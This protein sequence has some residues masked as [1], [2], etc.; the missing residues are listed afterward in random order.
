MARFCS[1]CGKEIEEWAAMCPHCGAQTTD[2]KIPQVPAED[3]TVNPLYII[4][5]I[6]LPIVGII[7]W[8]VQKDKT[9]HAAKTY[10]ITG[11]VVWGLGILLI[12]CA[13]I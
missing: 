8:A 1:K 12:A 5:S 11:L 2:K 10:L 7:L 3:D 9:P 4:L 6:L 13:G